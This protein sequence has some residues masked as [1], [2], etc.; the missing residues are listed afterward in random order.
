MDGCYIIRGEIRG[1][2]VP[3]HAPFLTHYLHLML[4]KPDGLFHIVIQP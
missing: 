3:Q 1:L 4:L 2:Y